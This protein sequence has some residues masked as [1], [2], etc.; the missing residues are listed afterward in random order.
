MN[1]H[2][3]RLHVLLSGEYALGGQDSVRLKVKLRLHSLKETP[4]E[5][6]ERTLGRT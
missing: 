3:K 2:N 1:Y 5:F 6:Y 4:K